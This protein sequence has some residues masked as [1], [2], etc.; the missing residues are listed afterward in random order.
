MHV[1]NSCLTSTYKN[2]TLNKSIICSRNKI[3]SKIIDMIWFADDI[4]VITQKNNLKNI[5]KIINIIK[6]NST[7]K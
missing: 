2:N 3:K 7:W 6:K 1:I 4:A 5:V